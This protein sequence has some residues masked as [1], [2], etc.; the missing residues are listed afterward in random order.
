MVSYT[1]EAGHQVNVYMFFRAHSARDLPETLQQ[2]FGLKLEEI[3]GLV[4][5]DKWGFYK[6]VGQPGERR[7][8]FY[9][10]FFKAHRD[11]G[12]RHT[13]PFIA[14]FN[15]VRETSIALFKRYGSREALDKWPGAHNLG[16]KL[17]QSH[18]CLPG[19]PYQEMLLLGLMYAKNIRLAENTFP[20]PL[21]KR[22]VPPEGCTFPLIDTL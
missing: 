11:R 7:E 3:H 18:A 5:N 22:T 6:D 9:K 20:H 8:L 14:N 21:R 10:S 19:V 15:H 12:C 1:T 2:L 16:V 13:K 17:D 4:V